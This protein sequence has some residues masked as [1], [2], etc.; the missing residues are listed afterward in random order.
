[1]TLGV[2]DVLWY[3]SGHG[4]YTVLRERKIV[5][6]SRTHWTLANGHKVPIKGEGGHR[7]V[8]QSGFGYDYWLSSKAY[9]DWCWEQREIQYARCARL[10]DRE[11][12]AVARVLRE[13]RGETAP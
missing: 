2:G 11:A 9:D 7:V 5:S 10:T 3:M 4:K 8:T 13:M 1:M 12:L 6:V